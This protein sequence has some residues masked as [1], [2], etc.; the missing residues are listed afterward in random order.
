MIAGSSIGTQV[1]PAIAA[2][3]SGFLAVS[4]DYRTS[5][6]NGPPFSSSGRRSDIY[7]MRLDAAG[8]PIDPAPLLVDR[9]FG[10]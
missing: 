1:A 3:G 5:P 8:L 10:D 7:A 2:G 9:T 6:F 4:Q